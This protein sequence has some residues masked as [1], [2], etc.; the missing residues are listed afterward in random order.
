M[1]R[2]IIVFLL[3]FTGPAWAG[4]SPW[5]VSVNEPYLEI[6]TG[7]GRG[8]PVF[9]TVEHSETVT[10]IKQKTGW[11]KVRTDRDKSGWIPRTELAKTRNTDGS[12]VDLDEIEQNAAIDN[13]WRAGFSTGDF[14]GA[15]V[16][17]VFGGYA[18][19]QNLSVEVSFSQAP[20]PIAENVMATG[21]LVH[22]F[23]PEKRLTPFFSLTAGMLRT[24][25]S[26]TL[27]QTEDR[28]DQIAAAGVGVRAWVSKRFVVRAE[29]RNYVVFTSRDD[30]QEIDEWKAGFTFLF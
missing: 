10:V 26:A 20:G 8:Y 24:S 1:S 15:N 3:L 11:Y 27:V 9:Y 18:L 12:V 14:G 29:Y 6:R 5:M 2:W 13:R 16:L 17:S 25:P 19:S 21:S 30:N 22:Q 4:G 28:T 7:P 23:I